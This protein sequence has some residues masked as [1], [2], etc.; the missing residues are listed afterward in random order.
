MKS[1]ET[2]RPSSILQLAAI[3]LDETL[4][5]HGSVPNEAVRLALTAIHET[6]AA[7]MVPDKI[8][9]KYHLAS[10][11]P[12]AG[13]TEALCA[14]LKTWK[15]LSFRPAAGALVV[16]QT[17]KEIE[18]CIERSGLHPSD[19]A[20]M[21][22]RGHTLNDMGLLRAEDSPVLFTTQEKL[23]HLCAGK[24]FADV[25]CL[26]FKGHP[27]ALRVWDEAFLPSVPA[28]IR[29]DIIVQ[30]FADLRPAAPQAVAALEAF[31]DSLSADTVGGVVEV[32][33]QISESCGA[34]AG[35]LGGGGMDHWATLKGLAGKSAVVVHG[36]SRG[37]YL[38]GS[39]RDLP[40]D[41]APALILDA[42]G[43]VREAYRT[44]EAAGTLTR[45]P[46]AAQNYQ[47]LRV[48]HW[49][50]AGSR[51]AL[52]APESRLE[53]LQAAADIINASEAGKRWLVVHPQDR[54]G[55]ASLSEGLGALCHDPSRISWLHWGN[56]HG[57]NDFRDIDRV[58]VLGVWNYP[59]P[60]YAA[61]HMAA[62][63][64]P[65]DA[66]QADT[67]DAIKAGEGRHNLL[68]AVCRASVRKGTDGVCGDC[69]VYI[70][71]KLGKRGGDLL[72]STFPGASI[73]SWRPAGA[74]LPLAVQRAASAIEGALSA[75]GV[76]R[77]TK[78][79]IKASLGL[80]SEGGLA[81]VL[82][83]TH[84]KV[85]ANRRG[86]EVTRRDFRWREAA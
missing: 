53:I 42:S 22:E 12:G 25:A 30:P 60:A 63:G 29:K 4:T 86:V 59:R 56:H 1:Q 58:M 57:T 16:L 15:S 40:A 49:E 2:D 44:M 38:A 48:H 20:I 82:R 75:P 31:S 26:Y 78:G 65:E 11:D 7:M 39:Y 61:L 71:A 35:L 13:K 10:V 41:F 68:Q 77:V 74:P 85:W 79:A 69:E 84:F 24:A 70:I 28:A 62:G 66:A 80:R 67:M 32:P 51:S 14:F 47:R 23:R 33:T 5:A 17:R 45:L 27:R 55:Q 19:F 37:L 46:S 8:A 50:R 18:G 64:L 81:K 54:Q 43:R 21:V 83:Q 9:A 76:D 73:E 6:M 72:A 52:T 3:R 34:L 36:G